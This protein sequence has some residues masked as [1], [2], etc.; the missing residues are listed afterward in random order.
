MAYEKLNLA[1]GQKFTAAHVTHI[2]DGIENLEPMTVH[3]AA[4]EGTSE[5]T[6]DKTFAEIDAA[7]SAGRIVRVEADM[8]EEGRYYLPAV[9]WVSGM[10][11]IF[12]LNAGSVATVIINTNGIMV[13]M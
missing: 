5:Y 8:G 3:V 13:D 7:L 6:A 1:D 11:A 4:V 10:Q 9:A 12:L 2:E